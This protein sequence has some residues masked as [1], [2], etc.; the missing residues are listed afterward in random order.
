MEK[1]IPKIDFNPTSTSIEG[2]EIVPLERIAK[3][4]DKYKI[5]PE[6]PHQLRFYNLIFITAGESKHFI[7]FKWH[8][9][10]QNNFIFTSKDQINAFD[11]SKKTKGF[12]FI[13]NSE[14]LSK[15]LSKLPEHIIFRLFTPQL[16]SPILNIPKKSNFNEYL[17][18]IIKEYSSDNTINKGLI[19]ENLFTILLAIA[20][21]LKQVENS[22]VYNNSNLIIFQKFTQLL[23]KN[24]QKSRNAKLYAQELAI[25]YKHLNSICKTTLNKTAKSYID[26]YV[27]LQAKRNIINLDINNNELGYLL[28]FDDPTNFNKFFKQRTGLTPKQFKNSITKN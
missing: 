27:I 19:I 16:F 10:K 12:C 6:T 11:F 17:S 28:G 20:E 14:Y 1:D 7:D 15:T 9:I 4:K 25:S 23:E 26:E 13:F 24:Y 3:N 22:E 5:N 8:D 21:E 18:L 2:F